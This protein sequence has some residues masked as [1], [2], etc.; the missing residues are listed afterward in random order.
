MFQLNSYLKCD[1]F[2]QPTWFSGENKISGTSF[3]AKP[4]N[5]AAELIAVIAKMN[6]S[7]TGWFTNFYN[8]SLHFLLMSCKI[9]EEK[10][11][12]KRNSD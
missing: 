10:S 6:F 9:V 5:T 4:S 12:N 8:S 7:G 3:V 11:I 2:L 1:W